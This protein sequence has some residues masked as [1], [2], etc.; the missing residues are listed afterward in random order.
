[1]VRAERGGNNTAPARSH[2]IGHQT[3]VNIV[4]FKTRFFRDLD[5]LQ[6]AEERAAKRALSRF[7]AFVR[8]R[9]RSSMRKRKKASAPG[10]PPSAHVGLIRKLLFF[11]YE[12]QTKSVIVG[13]ALINSK[14]GKSLVELHEKGGT[15]PVEEVQLGRE[16]WVRK[17]RVSID[18]VPHPTRVRD[19]KY[20]ARPYMKPAF[21]AELPKAADMFKNTVK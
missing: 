6:N 3:L 20:P 17:A 5:K 18:G 11:A 9:A 2:S 14:H 21:D 13:P 19:A 7:G 4:E 12:A 1:M 10:Q 16:F 8:T 15:L